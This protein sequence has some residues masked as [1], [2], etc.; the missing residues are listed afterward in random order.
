MTRSLFPVSLL[1]LAGSIAASSALSATPPAAQGSAAPSGFTA[2]FNERDLSGWVGMTPRDPRGY[3]DL[4]PETEDTQRQA[5]QAAFQ[6]HWRVQNG[7]LVHDGSGPAATSATR[8]GDI[9]LRLEYQVSPK[10][11]ATITGGAPAAPAALV[12]L[13]GTPLTQWQAAMAKAARPAGQWNA[14]RVVQ[15][16]ERTTVHLNDRLIADHERMTNSWAPALPLV[17]AGRIQL[18]GRS[19]GV[20]WRR[21][22]VR[23]IPGDEANRML[24]AKN[25]TGFASL[26]NGKDLTGWTGAVQ[27]YEVVDGAIRCKPKQGGVL[28]TEQMYRD[29]AARLEFKL[30]PGGNNG[31]AIRYPGTG[32]TAYVGMTELQILD[33]TAPQY[34]KLDPRQ[35]HGSVY[36]MAAAQ[37][38]YQRP[39]GEWNFQ[40]V[41]VRG[42]RITVELNGTVIVDADV[43]TIT[44][45]AG[46]RAHPG[47]DRT[48]GYFGFAGHS[49]PVEFR[50]VSIKSIQ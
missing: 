3:E 42:S 14:L 25:T 6:Q 40:E 28:H 24:A 12:Y 11:A 33:D 23:A 44:Q 16:G 1:V 50:N 38:G 26:F 29:F 22:F 30:P 34:A 48:E 36:G 21:V 45:F 37:R 31:L 18:E 4:A 27:S 49:D 10:P 20:R 5:E 9:E 15:L 41:T 13:R 46:N 43:S 32:D 7:E 39:V 19:A 35:Y 47:K 8:Y 17:R 2:L